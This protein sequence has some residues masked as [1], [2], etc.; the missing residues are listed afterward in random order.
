M[1]W[2]PR[3]TTT[4]A[5][6][7]DSNGDSKP[8]RH[9]G[10][11]G[12]GK[13]A[14]KEIVS[15]TGVTVRI[16]P[17]APAWPPEAST[18]HPPR[19]CARPSHACPSKLLMGTD[20]PAP[21]TRLCPSMCLVST[22]ATFPPHYTGTKLLVQESTA[23]LPPRPCKHPKALSHGERSPA[24]HRPRGRF[25][26]LP[27]PLTPSRPPRE[28]SAGFSVSP[29]GRA[30]PGGRRA[31]CGHPQCPHG[32]G[33]RGQEVGPSVT[34]DLGVAHSESLKIPRPE[35]DAERHNI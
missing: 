21:E 15:C 35:T 7:F 9:S 31:H 18:P 4:E 13:W 32:T 20:M 16:N 11:E 3:Q 25:L 12:T 23:Q 6:G 19:L 5:Y 26:S 17:D 34:S 8:H 33:A 2:Q 30:A 24:E 27:S 28:P 14:G 22:G 1:S 29:T 10:G